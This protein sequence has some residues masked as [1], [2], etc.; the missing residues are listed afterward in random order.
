MLRIIDE[1]QKKLWQ[2]FIYNIDKAK[3]KKMKQS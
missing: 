3:K 1:K 2:L